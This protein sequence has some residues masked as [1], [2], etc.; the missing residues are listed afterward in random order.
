MLFWMTGFG[1]IIII[2]VG[3]TL[4]VT[5][6]E[7][8]SDSI[9]IMMMSTIM[10]MIVMAWRGIVVVIA[11]AAAAA[12]AII[13]VNFD[14]CLK[15]RSLGIRSWPGGGTVPICNRLMKCSMN[16]YASCF[17]H[18][19]FDQCPVDG[20]RIDRMSKHVNI[21]GLQIDALKKRVV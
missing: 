17:R 3:Y 21:E 13:I 9:E 10:T 8:D 19:C 6:G 20:R 16:I 18:I 7:N 2:I 4:W 15:V 1:A 5:L 14:G 12:T 11:A